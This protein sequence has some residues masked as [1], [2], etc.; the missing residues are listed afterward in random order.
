MAKRRLPDDFQD[1]LKLLNEDEAK[2]L[3]GR[4]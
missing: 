4:G 1:F 2:Y 3:F